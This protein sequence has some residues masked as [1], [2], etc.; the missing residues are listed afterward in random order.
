[1]KK[2]VGIFAAAAVLATSAFAA[3]VSAKVQLEGN[4]F[5]FN[6]DKSISMFDIN[7]PSDQAWN[8]I[9]KTSVGND[10]AGASFGIY[11][12]SLEKEGGWNKAWATGANNFKVWLSPMEGLKFIFGNNSFNLNQEHI[13]WSKSDSGID[14]Q[15]G[16][17]LNYSANG[18]SADL[19]LVSPISEDK[20]K[21][22]NFKGY[23]VSPWMTKADGGDVVINKTGLKLQYGADFGTV[24]AI[25]VAENTFKTIKFGA[26]YANNF[27][28]INIFANVLGYLADSDFNKLRVELYAEGNVDALAWKLF[29]VVEVYP[30]GDDKVEALLWARVDYALDGFGI[31]C[32]IEDEGLTKIMK[33][34][35]LI[36]QPGVKGNVGGAA[37]DVGVKFAIDDPIAVTV[38]VT[39]SMEF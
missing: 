11:T 19:M 5:K 29:P 36:V 8:P 20:D 12:G 18:F 31:Y 6:A 30:N 39:I 7:K 28:G 35:A 22:G 24:N 21:D 25:L 15:L 3:D 17:S 1:M 26:G 23:K 33:G 2:I 4:L 10:K 27:S 37:W 38:P 32:Q 16:Y 9:F 14:E 34:K 13:T